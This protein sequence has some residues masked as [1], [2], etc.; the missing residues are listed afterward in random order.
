MRTINFVW[1]GNYDLE[2]CEKF[3]DYCILYYKY[4]KTR[5][6]VA[7]IPANLGKHSSYATFRCMRYIILFR[8]LYIT[9]QSKLYKNIISGTLRA[10]TFRTTSVFFV[11]ITP[12][13][14]PI[15]TSGRSPAVVTLPIVCS[16][17]CEYNILYYLELR[18]WQKKRDD[19]NNII[20]LV[21]VNFV[22]DFWDGDC[23]G[24]KAYFNVLKFVV[25][26]LLWL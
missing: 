24:S 15:H 23:V 9:A 3:A 20:Y 18:R 1:C 19:N 25:Y 6:L 2:N 26:I 4:S 12:S 21:Y 16:M 7:A 14:S 22:N 13:L 5:V 8:F 17:P 10:E 11:E